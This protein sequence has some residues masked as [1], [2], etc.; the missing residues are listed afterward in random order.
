MKI[1][2]LL[3]LAVV[4]AVTMAKSGHMIRHSLKSRHLN[5]KRTI[6][7]SKA[8][9]HSPMRLKNKEVDV[10]TQIIKKTQDFLDE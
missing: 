1:S 8:A 6:N 9:L 7:M 2:R 5:K 10:K 4:L 3:V